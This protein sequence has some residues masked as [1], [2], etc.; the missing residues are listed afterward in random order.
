MGHW[1]KQKSN[2]HVSLLWVQVKKKNISLKK[3]EFG[4][5]DVVLVLK[6]LPATIKAFTLRL[7][8]C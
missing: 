8:M 5:Y 3:K 2:E 4:C 6:D 7:K 1:R